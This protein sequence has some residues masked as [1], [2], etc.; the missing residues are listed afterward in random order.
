MGDDM[1]MIQ[2]SNDYSDDED[3]ADE[4]NI[5]TFHTTSALTPIDT[6]DPI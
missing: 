2:R 4:A 3:S 6:T 1:P 5:D